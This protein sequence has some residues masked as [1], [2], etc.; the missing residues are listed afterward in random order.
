MRKLKKVILIFYP[1]FGRKDK[2]SVRNMQI[3]SINYYF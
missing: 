2:L 3:M 1:N